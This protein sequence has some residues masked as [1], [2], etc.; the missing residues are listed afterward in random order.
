MRLLA[1]QIEIPPTPTP[2]ARDAHLDLVA[3]NL[4]DALAQ[5]P[6]DLVVLPELSAIDYSRD[7]FSRLDA[8]AEDLSGPSFERFRETARRFDVA[9]VYGI[10]RR[11]D[12]GYRISQ[13]AVGPD[14]EVMGCFDKL[15][16]AQYGASMEK[17]YFQRGEAPFSFSFRGVKIA[18]II[19]YD[20]RFPELARS[21]ALEHKAD[22]ILHCGAYARDPSFYSWHHF[23]VARALENQLYL[24]SLNRA[25]T[26]FGNSIFC[27]PWIDE[28][29][30]A[31]RFPEHEEAFI[32][33][34]IDP[35]RIAATRRE[36]SFLADRLPS[37]GS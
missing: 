15:H 23:V 13:V 30:P 36:Y 17:E 3:R 12:D 21:L 11:G 24:L 28:V 1:C 8:L 16:L 9:V 6:A 10:P 25:G 14:G 34:E 7:S 33:C 5:T 19:C 32:T 2:A 22:L 35:A 26:A 37:Y 31:L 29:S 27:P 20:I 18:P 4:A